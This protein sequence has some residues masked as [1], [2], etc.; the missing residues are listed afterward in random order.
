GES[1]GDQHDETDAP[2]EQGAPAVRDVPR[3]ETLP[4]LLQTLLRLRGAADAR[5]NFQC[6]LVAALDHQPPRTFGDEREQQQIQQR[7]KYLHAEHPAP[8]VLAHVEQEVRSEEHTS[9]LQSRLH[10]VCRLL[11]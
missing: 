8:V 11:L 6:L 1:E 7:W 9:E 5:Q 10:L 3:R 4:D 2:V